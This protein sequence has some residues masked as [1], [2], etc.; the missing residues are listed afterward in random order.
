[1]FVQDDSGDGAEGAVVE[2]CQV[3]FDQEIGPEVGADRLRGRG[4]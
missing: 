2:E 3:G 4:K 1:L